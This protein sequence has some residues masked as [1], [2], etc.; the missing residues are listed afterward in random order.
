MSSLA[1]QAAALD[2]LPLDEFLRSVCAT[3]TPLHHLI[4]PRDNVCARR[5]GIQ[6]TSDFLDLEEN[7]FRRLSLQAAYGFSRCEAALSPAATHSGRLRA[8]PATLVTPL[9]SAVYA[10][11]ADESGCSAR[12]LVQMP[13][14]THGD[15][16][17]HCRER[18]T[19][20]TPIHPQSGEYASTRQMLE[21]WLHHAPDAHITVTEIT[22]IDNPELQDIWAH[23]RT[24]LMNPEEPTIKTFAAPDAAAA[25]N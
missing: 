13:L 3:P 21:N 9:P 1:E 12:P 4:C 24:L 8:H 19:K 2:A 14:S 11:D 5:L 25:A 17:L 18:T 7:D 20:F 22:A 10:A 15:C 6:R 16:P 23:N